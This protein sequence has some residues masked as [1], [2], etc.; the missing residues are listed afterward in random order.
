M[1]PKW[2]L[3][4]IPIVGIITSCFTGIII[5][6]DFIKLRRERDRKMLMSDIIG[7]CVALTTLFVVS[8]STI[9]F[10]DFLWSAR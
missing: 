10:I 7:Y 4:I 8:A 1:L 3:Y 6:V 2:V 9:V 5:I